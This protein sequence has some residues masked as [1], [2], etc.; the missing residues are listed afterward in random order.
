MP[1]LTDPIAIVL[2]GAAMGAFLAAA[3]PLALSQPRTAPRWT[4]TLLM[5]AAAAHALDWLHWRISGD[6]G[7]LGILWLL[8]LMAAGFFWA[9]VQAWFVDRPAPVW[10]RLA[11]AAMLGAAGLFGVYVSS[12]GSRL[13]WLL[14]NGLVLGFMGHAL[15]T[16][17]R[18]FSGDLVEGRRRLRAPIILGAVSYIILVQ[19]GD[20]AAIFGTSFEVSPRLQ[21]GVLLALALAAAAMFFQADASVLAS[22]STAVGPGPA[23]PV[24]PPDDRGVLPQDRALAAR[25]EEAM[26]K[27][28]AWRDEALSIAA[29]AARLGA[30]EHRLRQLINAQLGHRNFAAFVNAH[31]IAAA[32][33]A[34]ADPENGRKP[35][36]AIAFELG[37]GSLGPFNRAFKEATGLTPT[38]WRQQALSG[39]PEPE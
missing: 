18:G 9:F 38:A 37:F 15:W 19:L 35:V 17:A 16:L 25:L 14:Y 1:L 6:R 7:A 29:L 4:A 10:R 30:P 11:P 21:A 36:S 33:A 26:A 5:V 3:A 39:S 13:P 8:S 27:D 20:L 34:L 23:P 12:L 31:R 28:Q 2:F 32:Q 24:P 22:G